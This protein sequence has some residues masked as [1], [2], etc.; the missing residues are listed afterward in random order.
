MN[1]Q[2]GCGAGARDGV[3]AAFRHLSA[4]H[5]LFVSLERAVMLQQTGPRKGVK[6]Q[7]LRREKLEVLKLSPSAAWGRYKGRWERDGSVS[8]T[9]GFP[10]SAGWRRAGSH[11]PLDR[12]GTGPPERGWPRDTT[13]SPSSW[14]LPFFHTV[15]FGTRTEAPSASHYSPQ[16]L[17][18]TQFLQQKAEPTRGQLCLEPPSQQAN[19]VLPQLCPA[20]A[21][22]KSAQEPPGTLQK[23]QQPKK[24]LWSRQRTSPG[25]D[26]HPTDQARL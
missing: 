4:L 2:R 6:K 26:P 9:P 20:S 18:G 3:A 1:E 14:H 11:E 21:T 5:K 17:P 13:V 19:P 12:G 23:V 7:P 22:G 8:R 25:P 10:C 16:T 24:C 15:G